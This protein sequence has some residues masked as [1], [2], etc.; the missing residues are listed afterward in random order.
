MRPGEMKHRVQFLRGQMSDDGLQNAIVWGD[1]VN[2]VIGPKLWAKR[3]PISDAERWRAGQVSANI[4][5]RFVVYC[6][7]LTSSITPKDRLVCN[8][9]V[10]DI[11]GIKDVEYDKMWLEIT[12]A[13]RAS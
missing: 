5:A 6:S 12:V 8:G 1:P 4:T 3:T 13:A 7:A 11:M 9:T 10:Y 2:D